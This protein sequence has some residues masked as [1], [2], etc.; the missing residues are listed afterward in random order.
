MKEWFEGKTVAII[1]NAMSL[2][3]KNYGKEIDSHD[4]VVRLNKAALLYDRMD[5]EKSHGKKTDVWIFWNTS[6]YK[7][8][9]SKY[10]KVKKMH[11]G[12]QA[13]FDANTKQTDFVYP[14]IPNYT[15]LRKKSGQHNNPT[16]GL[17]ALDWIMSSSPASLDIYGFDWK[18]T[19]TYTDPKR[20]KD[21]GCPHDFATEKAYITTE[22]L[23][24]SNV[25]LRS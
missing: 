10:P 12:H 6:E 4:V 21:R 3:D 13:R 15:E 11:A 18:E 8:Q 20:I 17:I 19:P 25:R 2:F 22:F 7:N 24:L 1:G 14:M 5:V 9:F 16:T 23:S